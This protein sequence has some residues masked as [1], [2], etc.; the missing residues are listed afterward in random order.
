MNRIVIVPESETVFQLQFMCPGC[1]IRH[2]FNSTWNWNGDHE[3]PSVSPSIRTM[4]AKQVGEEDGE[5]VYE[6]YLCHSWI[7]KGKIK[8]FADCTHDKAGTQWHELLEIIE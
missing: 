2:S 4:G 8:F 1:N 3:F 6:D 7:T 5:P